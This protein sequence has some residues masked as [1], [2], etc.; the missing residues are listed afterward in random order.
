MGGGA[1]AEEG[2]G[3]PLKI[4]FWQILMFKSRI[5]NNMKSRFCVRFLFSQMNILCLARKMVMWCC[6]Y[7][8]L[9]G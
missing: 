9:E 6:P 5:T 4:A 2:D 3:L 1:T 8:V 7:Y